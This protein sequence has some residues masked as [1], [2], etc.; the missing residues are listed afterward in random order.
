MLLFP[1]LWNLGSSE[2]SPASL[3]DCP[4][5]SGIKAPCGDSPAQVQTINPVIMSMLSSTKMW[6]L[7]W[8]LL[9]ERKIYLKTKLQGREKFHNSD[10]GSPVGPVLQTYTYVKELPGFSFQLHLYSSGAHGFAILICIGFS[11]S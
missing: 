2:H 10:L 1:M 7:K 3:P 11:C 4:F 9:N 8:P 6:N 5:S